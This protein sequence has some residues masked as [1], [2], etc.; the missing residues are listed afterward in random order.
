M[1]VAMNYRIRDAPPMKKKIRAKTV[2]MTHRIAIAILL[3]PMRH[4]I[5][6]LKA[7][8]PRA[9]IIGAATE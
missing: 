7:V 9:T 4:P 5:T 3:F 6:T 2:A 1:Y 8:L